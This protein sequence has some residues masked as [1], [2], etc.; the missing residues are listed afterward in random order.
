MHARD[1]RRPVEPAFVEA[2]RTVT[3]GT[4]FYVAELLRAL[5]QD[6]VEGT[7]ADVG[8]IEC[9]TPRAVIDATLARLAR[10]PAEARTVT[11]A[12]ALME[13]S[14]ELRWIAALRG[15]DVDI[16]AAAADSLLELGL[17][18]SVAPC[19]FAHPILR[20]AVET[21]ISPARRGRLHH[22]A[23]RILAD[24]HMPID[25]VAAH[26]MQTP[27]LG[28]PWIV[29]VLARA[30]REASARGAPAGAVAYLQRALAERPA[31]RERRE[32]LLDIGKAESQL[33]S[34]QAPGHLREA[35]ALAEHPDEVAAVALWL[36]Q[37]LY[38][39]GALDEA[40]EILSDVV[41]RTDRRDSDA[42]RRSSSRR[43]CCRPP[44][45]PGR[46]PRPLRA[47]RRSR[48][49]RTARRSSSP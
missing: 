37:A 16:V 6:R 31:T 40:F 19:R 38:H 21:E 30:A 46:W 17:L 12:V 49:A 41:Q 10:L 7:A 20:S 36:G 2:C 9:L 1:P 14:A 27:P 11:E 45:R 48:R 4:P 13:P 44:V 43:I 29:S 8:A 25:A 15:F 23:A 22:G 33:H 18:R 47:P 39:C 42:T 5:R 3:G 32:L 26:L 28:E 24:A 35:L 34:P